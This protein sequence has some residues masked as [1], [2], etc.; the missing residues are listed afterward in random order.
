MILLARVADVKI[1]LLAR[2]ANTTIIL[3]ARV[4]DTQINAAKE[5]CCQKNF[6]NDFENELM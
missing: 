4:A 3:L 6:R 5:N 2:V 1:I